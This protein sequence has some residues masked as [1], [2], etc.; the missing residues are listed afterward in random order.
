MERDEDGNFIPVRVDPS[1]G[2]PVDDDGNEFPEPVPAIPSYTGFRPPVSPSIAAPVLR[3]PMTPPD[4][5]AANRDRYAAALGLR[6]QLA[7]DQG[8]ERGRD[9][10]MRLAGRRSGSGYGAQVQ[11][12]NINQLMANQLGLAIGDQALRRELGTGELDVKRHGIDTGERTAAEHNRTLETVADKTGRWHAEAAKYQADAMYGKGQQA[13]FDKLQDDLM[14]VE[15]TIKAAKEARDFDLADRLTRHRAELHRRLYQTP[16]GSPSPAAPA[17]T[18]PT[19]LPNASS[20]EVDP[21]AEALLGDHRF[22]EY[23]RWANRYGGTSPDEAGM[24]A[25]GN[26]LPGTATLPSSGQGLGA[27]LTDLSR[28]YGGAGRDPS[29]RAAVLASTLL[30]DMDRYPRHSKPEI[31]AMVQALTGTSGMAPGFREFLTGPGFGDDE[32]E[33]PAAKFIKSILA[34][35]VPVLTDEERRKIRK[36][37]GYHYLLGW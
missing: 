34:G 10:A 12:R 23:R 28:S 18:V 6:Q 2:K 20:V 26:R 11:Q 31:Q 4:Q 19:G 5:V 14:Q 8:I 15:A 16:G 37:E 3:G 36:R 25:Q 29:R 21:R 7:Q 1:T 27:A 33:K 13:Q 17:T 9:R 22:K 35:D 24:D 30:V 32:Y